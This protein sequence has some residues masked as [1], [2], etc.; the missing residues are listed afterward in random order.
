MKL[1]SQTCW[2]LYC[3]SMLLLAL[4]MS[5]RNILCNIHKIWADCANWAGGEYFWPYMDEAWAITQA[6]YELSPKQP[7]HSSS[8][9][10]G[11][12]RSPGRC[13]EGRGQTFAFIIKNTLTHVLPLY[14]LHSFSLSSWW[15]ESFCCVFAAHALY[16]KPVPWPF[17]SSLS[18]SGCKRASGLHTSF[19]GMCTWA[20]QVICRRRASVCV[21]VRVRACAHAVVHV[22]AASCCRLTVQRFANSGTI[23]STSI[24]RHLERE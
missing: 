24:Q 4:H 14:E 21:Y 18:T 16:G 11:I 12:Q 1:F 9:F 10:R 3:V 8:H 19:P 2:R 7:I 20:T 23:P 17:F 5:H 6:L 13:E 22:R 15:N